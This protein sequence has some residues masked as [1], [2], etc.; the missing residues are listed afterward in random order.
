MKRPF[1]DADLPMLA[2]F[3]LTHAQICIHQV[4]L[5]MATADASLSF[6]HSQCHDPHLEREAGRSEIFRPVA[7]TAT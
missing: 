6:S 3:V 5:H 1:G 4:S 2:C 7:F